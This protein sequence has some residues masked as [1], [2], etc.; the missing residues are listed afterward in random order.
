MPGAVRPGVRNVK[1]QKPNLQKEAHR[2]LDIVLIVLWKTRVLELRQSV[3][4]DNSPDIVIVQHSLLGFTIVSG[5]GS[6]GRDR[7]LYALYC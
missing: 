1:K 4:F 2:H 7:G 3:G 5:L 6:V